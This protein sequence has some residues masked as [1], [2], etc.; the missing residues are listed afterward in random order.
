MIYLSNALVL[1]WFFNDFFHLIWFWKWICPLKVTS[2]LKV[3]LLA[4]CLYHN[5]IRSLREQ[6]Q[7]GSLHEDVKTAVC[8]LEM[9]TLITRM[10]VRPW[11]E[12]KRGRVQLKLTVSLMCRP[13]GES[14]MMCGCRHP[15]V[16]STSSAHSL[17]HLFLWITSLLISFQ[18]ASVLSTHG[19]EGE[20]DG[21]RASTWVSGG[22][23]P[24]SPPHWF[25]F[26]KSAGEYV[27]TRQC[28]CYVEQ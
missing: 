24:L 26:S 1:P 12:A 23:W 10:W 22:H 13:C 18:V 2:A 14:G 9:T 4:F 20:G 11:G 28:Y 3:I 25:L 27:R 21:C 16:L 19:G 15:P 8:Q 6:R 7:I 17:L 5:R